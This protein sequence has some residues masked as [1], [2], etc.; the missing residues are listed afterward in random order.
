MNLRKVV[1]IIIRKTCPYWLR[2][3]FIA[4]YNEVKWYCFLVSCK[5]SML[6]K[7][8]MV[9][10][11][12]REFVRAT[13]YHVFISCRYENILNNLVLWNLEI[14]CHS[15]FFLCLHLTLN[16][17]K[18]IEWLICFTILYFKTFITATISAL[19]STQRCTVRS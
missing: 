6:I 9:C 1:K 7:A 8:N 5:F 16:V 10:S 18:I 17:L 3:G 19:T 12:F 2:V 13:S 14:L 4:N 15:I 11:N